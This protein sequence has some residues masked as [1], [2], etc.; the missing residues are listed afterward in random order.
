M[1]TDRDQSSEDEMKTFYVLL[2]RSIDLLGDNDFG[3]VQDLQYIA[4]PIV[5]EDE[6]EAATKA[7]KELLRADRKGK[8]PENHTTV[9]GVIEDGI[10]RPWLNGDF[11]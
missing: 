10:Y 8:V 5:A 2:L 6:N 11:R 7:K 9:L 4:G 1:L 3:S